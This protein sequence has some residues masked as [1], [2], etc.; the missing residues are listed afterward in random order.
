MDTNIKEKIKEITSKYSITTDK[1]INFKVLTEIAQLRKGKIK[2]GEIYINAITKIT[3]IDKCGNEFSM[4]PNA[5]KRGSWSPYESGSV[6]DP[7]YHMQELEKIVASK[8]GKIK[9][10]ER[11]INNSTKMIFIDQLGREFSMKP[12]NI[13]SGR[14]SPYES[15]NVYNNP[16]YHMKEL[17]E[18]AL[19]KGGKIKEG[20]KYLGSHTKMTFID[21]LGN[22][23]RMAPTSIK[24]DRWSPYEVDKVRDPKYHMKELEEIALSKGGNIKEGEKYINAK[25]KMIFIDQLG[26]EF[27]TIPSSVKLGCWSPYEKNYSE[28]ICRQIIEQLYNKN[29]PSCWDIIKREGKRS[30]QLDGYNPDLKIA[31]EYQGE[32][33]TFGWFNPDK[34]RQQKLL[35]EIKERDREKK[36]ICRNKDI[37]LL[38]IN[39]YK[40]IKNT[41]DLISQTI[42]DLK[43]SYKKAGYIIPDYISNIKVENIK[44]D[45]SKISHLVLRQKEVEEIALSKGGKLKAGE[46]YINSNTKMTFIDKLDNEFK[47]TPNRVKQGQWSP[48]ESGKGHD[49]IYHMKEIEKI[50]SAKSGKIKEGQYY[51]GANTKMIFIDKLGNEFEM[52]PGSIK[53]G[54]WSPYESGNV[55]DKQYHMK[56]IEKIVLSKGGKIKEGQYYVA[57][58]TKMIFIDQ[59]GNEFNMSPT[60]IKRGTW[61]PYES[62]TVRDPEYHMKELEE[63]V[64]SKRGKIKEGE[65]YVTA[66][67][68]MI[69]IDQLGNEFKMK[70]NDIKS[71]RWSPYESGNVYNNPEY[72]ITEIEEIVISKKGKIK[73][74]ERYVNNKTKMTFIDQSGNEFQMTPNA[75]KNGSWSPY[76]SGNVRSSEYHMKE[77]EKIVSSKGGKIKEGEIYI[78]AHTKMTFIDQ[79]GNEFRMAP[80][81]VKMGRW[82]KIR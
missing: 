77:L 81:Y 19:S 39:Y 31:F 70:P 61:S 59:L 63:I 13:K 22:E 60:C 26:N 17:D 12:S 62:G 41:Q 55:R 20:Q 29:F 79:L 7:N 27:E 64:L 33:H 1:N 10:N 56:E 82:N 50:V 53:M 67:T 3:F 25:T 36:Q 52:T 49:K 37:L 75:I 4:S 24:G 14:W 5:V 44:I 16:E 58:N 6:I 72:H 18:I 23:F 78:N 40:N 48:Y 8:G 76:E 11:Y 73:E 42:N 68:K 28:N 35:E 80:T 38:E 2:D 51:V 9:E 46:M 43:K 21:K 47:M 45:L 32:Q 69:F 71:G 15:G 74:G 57:A 54:N 30:L 34:N 66:I 65:T